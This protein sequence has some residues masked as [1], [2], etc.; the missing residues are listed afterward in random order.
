VKHRL[1]LADGRIKW[2]H[3]HCTNTFDETGKPLRSVGM[4]Q[5]ITEQQEARQRC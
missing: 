3:E 2:V 5:D 4:S 1:L